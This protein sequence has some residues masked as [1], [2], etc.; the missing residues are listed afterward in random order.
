MHVHPILVQ[1]FTAVEQSASGKVSDS[2]EVHTLALSSWS[3]GHAVSFLAVGPE[4][5]VRYQF[6]IAENG[7]AHNL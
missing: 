3:Q 6:R 4:N 5:L 2:T 1:Y 7:S